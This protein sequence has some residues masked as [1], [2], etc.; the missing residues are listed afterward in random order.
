MKQLINS[1]TIVLCGGGTGGH[2]FPL[3]ALAEELESRKVRFYFLGSRTG[4]EA[5]LVKQ[6]NWRF[7]P[8]S[9]GKWRRYYSL[10]SIAA[11]LVGVA[12]TIVGFF[13]ALSFLLTRRVSTIFSKGGYVALPVV[14]AGWFLGK[15]IVIHESDSVMGLT[16]R[17]SAFFADEVLVAFDPSMYSNRTKK[18]R[19]VG[20]PIRKNLSQA[21]KLIPPQKSRPMILVIAGIQ[22]SRFINDLIRKSLPGLIKLADIIHITGQAEYLTYKAIAKKL[23][24]RL[25]SSYKPFGF[26]EREL[27]YY[28][29]LSD[30]VVSRAGA[31]II[32]EVSLFGKPL[33]L[34]PLPTSASD[35]QNKNAQA[36]AGHEAA[37][38]RSEIELNSD[39]FLSEIKQLLADRQALE[40]IGANLQR[41]FKTSNAVEEIIN[42]L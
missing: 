29:Q 5:E 18:F 42:L 30:L 9:A 4:P 24:P 32:A 6:H 25:R 10:T 40:T 12:A 2:I 7:Q 1:K 41:Y 19:Q 28:L 23:P 26:I 13:E 17:L 31:T 3:F 8:I 15:R 33:Y 37:I 14:L 36:V 35:H 11:N 27:A 34:I 38:Y 21:A 20:I 22:G 39:K 16:N